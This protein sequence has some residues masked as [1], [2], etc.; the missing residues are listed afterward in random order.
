MSNIDNTFMSSYIDELNR[1]KELL[2]WYEPIP[3]W[4]FWAIM[5]RQEITIAEKALKELNVVDMLKCYK[6]MQTCK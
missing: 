4:M 1:V 2:T 5:L 3:E 6:S